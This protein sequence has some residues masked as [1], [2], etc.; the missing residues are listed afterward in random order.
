MTDSSQATINTGAVDSTGPVLTD[1]SALPGQLSVGENLEIS[2][3]ADD[4]YGIDSA[5]FTFR[6][7]AGNRMFLQDYDDTGSVSTRIPDNR[8]AGTII[9]DSIQLIDT[10]SSR[11]V[12]N[13][14]RDCDLRGI[15]QADTHNFDLSGYDLNLARDCQDPT[16]S[17]P[18]FRKNVLLGGR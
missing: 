8:P 18:I 2:Y 12:S 17:M 16:A 13:Y 9:L 1:I 7:S 15:N 14:E 6:D 3:T 4:A 11:N 10:A 5:T